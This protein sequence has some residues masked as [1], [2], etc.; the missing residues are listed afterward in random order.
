MAARAA[1][2]S[3]PVPVIALAAGRPLHSGANKSAAAARTR[4]QRDLVAVH[5]SRLGEATCRCGSAF[6]IAVGVPE[7]RAAE[8][9]VRAR[10]A[11]A[12]DTVLA[13]LEER[14][15]VGVEARNALAHLLEA[16]R[17]FAELR[18]AGLELDAR[19]G[20]AARVLCPLAAR[21]REASIDLLRGSV[22]RCAHASS[23]M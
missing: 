8:L 10:E 21:S 16:G 5:A 22:P 13:S 18:T 12:A 6:G 3:Q 4:R 2:A 11:A 23:P 9:R 14:N 19:L 17:P 15:E 20:K 7:P 1:E